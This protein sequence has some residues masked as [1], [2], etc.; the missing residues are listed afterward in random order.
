MLRLVRVDRS[1]SPET[2]AAM[3]VAFDPVCRSM[4]PLVIEDN[5]ARRRLALIILRH[6]DRGERDPRRLSETTSGE[7]AWV[8]RGG[9]QPR[10]NVA[11]GL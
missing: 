8:H 9:L 7:W 5:D 4:S 2:V 1:Y 6:V 3:G 11:G 10:Q